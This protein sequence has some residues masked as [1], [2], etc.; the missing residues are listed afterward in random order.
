MF[1]EH[2]T[3]LLTYFITY[4]ALGFAWRSWRVYRAT[5][6]NPYVLPT[7]DNAFGYVALA[8]KCTMTACL[9]LALIHSIGPEWLHQLGPMPSIAAL[10]PAPIAW[11]ILLS[12]LAMMLI[13]QAQMGPSWRIGIDTST[14]TELI[15][16]GLYRQSRNPIFLSIRASLL[17][18]FLLTPNAL[19][20]AILVAGEILMQVQVRLEER[21]LA[22]VH[23][24]TYAA[25]CATVPRWL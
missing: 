1:L 6:V 25:Y 19:S 20:L 21:H 8:F 14:P 23:P 24:A 7:S 11:T 13:A 4:F 22:L 17:G 2:T 5:G 18:L 10:L 12:A 3:M 15:Q 16:S 9:G